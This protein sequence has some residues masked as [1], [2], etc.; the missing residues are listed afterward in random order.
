MVPTTLKAESRQAAG[1]SQPDEAVI[2]DPGSQGW[3]SS[4]LLAAKKATPG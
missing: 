1:A 3:R 4:L 2:L